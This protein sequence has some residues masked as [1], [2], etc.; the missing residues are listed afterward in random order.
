[1]M[2]SVS[3][4]EQAELEVDRVGHNDIDDFV[5]ALREESKEEDTSETP[6]FN[7]TTEEKE[8]D[9]SPGSSSVLDKLDAVVES[10]LYGKSRAILRKNVDSMVCTSSVKL[11]SKDRD[12]EN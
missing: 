8:T 2:A 5:K 9:E 12:I 7:K 3:D 11:K 1:M 6:L 10:E 4:A